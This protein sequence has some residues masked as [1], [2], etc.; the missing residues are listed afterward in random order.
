MPINVS[1]LESLYLQWLE[2]QVERGHRQQ[3]TLEYYKDRLTPLLDQIGRDKDADDVKRLDAENIASSWHDV[4]SLQRLFNWGVEME[5][6]QRN[7][8]EKL[9]TPPLGERERIPTRKELALLIRKSTRPLGWFLLTMWH[10]IARPHEVRTLRFDHWND[11]QRV[12]QLHSFKGKSR[13]K[14]GV[15]KRVIPADSW[16]KRLIA[17]RLKNADASGHIFLN[18]KGKPWTANALRIAVR[19]AAKRAG[20]DVEGQER[21]VAYSMRHAG[22]TRATAGGVRDRQ[23]ADIMGHASTRTTARYQHL[24]AEDLVRAIG[25]ATARRP[26]G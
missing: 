22:A 7:P 26:A 8:L 13:R 9:T 20:L 18:T 24:A 11:E 17:R 6:I 21:I 19:K 10:T 3:R 4:Q 12:F 5:L 15:K 25:Q 1:Q 16:M 2:K 23:L 14:D